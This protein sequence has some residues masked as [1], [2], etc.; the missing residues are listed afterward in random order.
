MEVRLHAFRTVL[1]EPAVT[2]H[3]LAV[4]AE[5]AALLPFT[6]FASPPSINRLHI[7]LSIYV[8]FIDQFKT[9]L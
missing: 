4:V 3:V 6:A 9:I 1:V 2:N 8:N 5:I 7:Y